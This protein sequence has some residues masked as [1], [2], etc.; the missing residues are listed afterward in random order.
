MREKIVSLS[1]G[2]TEEKFAE[3]IGKPVSAVADMRKAGKLPIIQ[4]KRPGSSR[5]ENYVYLPAWNNGLKMAYESLPKEMRDG[6]LVW[7]GLKS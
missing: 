2:V 6:W 7:L 4:M 1:D 5:A 3:L